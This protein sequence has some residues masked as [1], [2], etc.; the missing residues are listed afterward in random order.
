MPA[1]RGLLIILSSPS[2]A[3]KSTLSRRLRDWDPSIVFSVSATT[4]PPRVGEV[5]GQDY[6]FLTQEAFKASV[7][8]AGMLEHAHVFGHFYGSPKAPVQAAIEAG[9]D[10]LFDIDWQGA[11]QIRNSDLSAA[12]VDPGTAPPT[13]G[14]R[15]GCAR[16]DRAPDA[17]KLGRDQ[18]LGRL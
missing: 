15:A 10:V 1:R 16:G 3:G 7:A 17:E 12:A 4:R 14:A 13:R 11:Q 9:K 8:E 18:P 6:H 2:G 5:D